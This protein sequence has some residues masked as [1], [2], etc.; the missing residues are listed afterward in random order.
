[1]RCSAV[2][3]ITRYIAREM[4]VPLAYCLIGFNMIFVLF[5]LFD[6]LSHLMEST[7][8]PWQIAVYYLSYMAPFLEWIAPAALLLATLYTMWRLSHNGEITA[9]RAGG[10]GFGQIAAPLLVM[11]IVLA[12]GIALINEFIAPWSGDWAKRVSNNRFQPLPPNTLT[13]IPFYNHAQHR[14]WFVNRIDA[15]NP[16]LLEGV[17]IT[18]ER[19]DRTRE[20]ELIASRAEYLD[21]EWWFFSPRMQHFDAYNQVRTDDAESMLTR[22]LVRMPMLSEIPSDFVNETRE[23]RFFSLRDMLRYLETHP[24]LPAQAAA[25]KWYQVHFRLASPWSAVVITLFAIPAGVA[26]G[27]QSVSRGVL[28]AMGL[29][30][31]FFVLSQLCMFVGQQ[32][33]IPPWLGAWTPNG[34]FLVAGG[35]LY[36][37][38]R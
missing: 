14:I 6:N 4:L 17:R 18:F 23:W 5:D 16:R 10:I 13:D 31:G 26:S 9:M 29:Y 34:V 36:A 1:M 32:G 33:L 25:E 7:M 12:L 2:K 27:R 20:R 30:I 28:M 3:I 15:D 35:F 19:R 22:P 37:R 21:G 24:T 8:P 11:S 38:Q